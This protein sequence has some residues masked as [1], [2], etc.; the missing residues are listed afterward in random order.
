MTLKLE[1]L[2]TVAEAIEE[3]AGDRK[4]A[5]KAFAAA[6]LVIAEAGQE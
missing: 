1:Q 5:A 2:A 3:L 4:V 6:V